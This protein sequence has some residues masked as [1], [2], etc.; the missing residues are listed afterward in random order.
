MCR[1][2]IFVL[3]ASALIITSSLGVSTANASAFAV[4]PKAA[5]EPSSQAS[6]QRS[7]RPVTRKT[8]TARFDGKKVDISYGLPTVG[9]PEFAELQR[10]EPGSVLR[11]LSSPAIRMRAEIALEFG[12]VRVP[13]GNVAPNYPGIY[14]VWLRK[15]QNGWELCFNDEGDV[16]GTQYNSDAD[17]AVVG[18]VHEVDEGSLHSPEQLSF[19]LTAEGDEGRLEIEWGEHR[20][21]AGFRAASA[22]P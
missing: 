5:Q 18:L 9:G 15:S 11:L 17:R 8:A 2:M 20:W 3:G 4:E 12:D 1:I 6:Q 13:T 19:E 7:R 14:S 16:W 22:S 10:L 21:H